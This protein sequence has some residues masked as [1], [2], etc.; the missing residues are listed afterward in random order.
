[1]DGRE[2]GG[3]RK[4][5]ALFKVIWL[6]FWLAIAKAYFDQIGDGWTH[7]LWVIGAI[8]ISICPWVFR[9]GYRKYNY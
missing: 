8:C 5:R 3:G 1:M 2:F 7:L 4:M 6:I 9:W